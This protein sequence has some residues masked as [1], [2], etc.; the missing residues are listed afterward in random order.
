[1][2]KILKDLRV[3]NVLLSFPDSK[4]ALAYL[5][6][7]E[8]QPFIIFCDVN[9]PGETGLDLKKQIDDDPVLRKKSIPF[10]FYSSSVSQQV[11]DKAYA[12]MTVQ[13]FFEK[14][15]NYEEIRDDIH[16]II[17]YWKRCRHPNVV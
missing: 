2:Q 12:E 17:S 1:M 7:S 4:T 16:S 15:I 13:G 5:K 3:K 9:L 14:A 10:I 8:D 11:I 6:V